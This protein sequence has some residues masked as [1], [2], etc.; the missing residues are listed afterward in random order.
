MLFAGRLPVTPLILIA[1][2][3]I[4]YPQKKRRY[5]YLATGYSVLGAILGYMIGLAILNNTQFYVQKLHLADGL[6]KAGELF[7]DYGGLT[8]FISSITVIPFKLFAITSGALKYPIYKFIIYTA[9]AR[10]IHFYIAIVGIELFTALF[11]K[12]VSYIK[13]ENYRQ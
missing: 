12:I 13:R 11:Q 1:P 7:L 8:I 6:S 5:V 10:F 2:L 3:C 9:V 4:K